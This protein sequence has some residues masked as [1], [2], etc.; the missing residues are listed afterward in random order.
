MTSIRIQSADRTWT[1]ETG[2]GARVFRIGR[3]ESADIVGT[4][5]AVSRRH[6]EIR[7]LGDGPGDGWEV[8]DVGSSLGTWVNGRRVDRAT[9]QGTTALGFGDQ[10][11]S[12]QLTVTVSAP[13]APAVPAAP[14]AP[15]P[16]TYA[17][18]TGP[19]L[20]PTQELARAP[21]FQPS[22]PRPDL[23]E[24]TVVTRGLGGPSGP[25]L[26]V[27]RRVG[28]DL[29][30]PGGIPVRIGRDPSLEVHADDQAV[31]RLHAVVEPRPDGWWWVDRSTSGTFVEGEQVT[32]FKIDEPVEISLGHPTAGY[33]IEVVP[34]V[35]AELATAG[36]QRRKRRRALLL[37]AA[38]V[39]LLL[40]ASGLTWGVV[41]L[42]SDDGPG[43]AVATGGTGTATG[44]P[45]DR[46]AA[47]DRAKAAAVLLQAVDDTGQVIWSGSGS[48]I[49]DDGLIL[50]NAHVGDPDAPG[51]GSS[52]PDPAYLEVSLT[53]GDDDAPATA[54][55]RANPIVSDGYLDIAVLQINADIDGNA[56]DLA[57]L[58]LP[59]PLPIGDSDALRTGDRIIALGYPAIG[60]VAA[61]GDRPLTVTEGVVSTF[62]ADPVIGTDRG[63]IDSDVRLGSGNSGGPSINEAGEIIGLNTRVITAASVD[64]GSITQGSALIVPVNL[65]ADVL[66]IARNGGDPDYVSPFVSSMP[67]EQGLPTGAGAV[68]NGWSADKDGSGCSG[69]STPDAPQEM[70]GVEVGDTLQAEFTLKG[71]PSG[72]PL[73]V[74]FL[75]ADGT[76]VDTLSGTWDG[77]ETATCIAAPLTIQDAVPGV[78]AELSLG[79]EGEVAAENPVVFP[80]N[81]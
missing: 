40:A 23:L 13:V 8:V 32:S 24:Q 20:P 79:Q 28:G 3:E 22:P 64:A 38:A 52:E 26:L 61:Q 44:Q 57:D 81:G 15:P 17:A 19:P 60:N 51:Q 55:Y 27:R 31:S 59:E 67:G 37:G 11:R 72:L 53:T 75:L 48:V 77:D 54:A 43:P 58:D 47:L 71:V 34:V 80:D 21:Q 78:T 29:R 63:S 73:S 12:F 76:R 46:A 65:A 33:E 45:V 68:A 49:S 66:E 39:V 69:T 2:E 9:L 6:A 56:V 36:I 10:G 70:L 62:Q 5:P 25:G 35:A 1:A 7:A 14:P 4:D 30:F 42:V 74:D 18:P 50:T 41:S 16:P